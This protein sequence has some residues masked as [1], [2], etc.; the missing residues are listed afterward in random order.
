MIRIFKAICVGGVIGA[1]VASIDGAIVGLLVASDGQQI[2]SW[3]M[4]FALAGAILGG[5]AGA[6]LTRIRLRPPNDPD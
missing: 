3:V 1:A 5:V 2:L 6:I 4:G